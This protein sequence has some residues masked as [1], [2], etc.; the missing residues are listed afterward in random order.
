MNK[1]VSLLILPPVTMAVQVQMTRSQAQ[2]K[3]DMTHCQV[4]TVSVEGWV[5]PPH[6]KLS[7]PAPSSN[8]QGLLSRDQLD[9]WVMRTC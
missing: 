1:L 6:R 3:G 4:S 7:P 8:S 9:W 2:E 5:P